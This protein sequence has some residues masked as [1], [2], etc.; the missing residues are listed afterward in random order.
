MGGSAAGPGEQVLDRPLE[1][2]VGREAD[3]VSDAPPLQRL[4]GGRDGEGHVGAHDDGPSPIL[5]PVDDGEKHLV[6]PI[7]T[8]DVARAELGGETVAVLVEAEL[9]MIAARLEVMGWS[10]PDAET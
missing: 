7:R 9:G 6:P 10:A 8:V 4:G 2:V 5:E 3:G 1:D